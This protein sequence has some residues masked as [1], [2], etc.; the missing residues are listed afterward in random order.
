MDAHERVRLR[1]SAVV[2]RGEAV[3]LLH[4]TAHRRDDWVL[5]GG[6]PRPGEGTAACA[7]RE[8]REETG[9][10]VETGRCAFVLE[11]I[12]PASRD[13]T[14][15]LIFLATDDGGEPIRTEPG[16][17]PSFVELALLPQLNLR[18]PIGGH[19]RGI[20]YRPAPPAAPYLGN[21]WRPARP[22]GDLVV[23]TS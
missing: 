23:E 8:V 5:P 20:G 11:T 2:F 17:E 6:C 3:L 4:R 16:L 7:R 13:R 1:C 18:P 12:D 14:V 15:E 21:L 10:G 9:L 19:L 22:P